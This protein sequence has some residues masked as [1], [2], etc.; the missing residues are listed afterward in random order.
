MLMDR[1]QSPMLLPILVA[2]ATAVWAYWAT[3]AEVVER[4][5]DDPQ[6]SHGFL[7]PLF[8]GYLLWI[9]RGHLRA[10]D[11]NAR[12]W[13]LGIVALAGLLRMLSHFFYQT[14]LDTGS[15]LICLA[16]IAA[17]AGGRRTLIWAGPAILFLIFML[18][19]P[20]RVQTALGGSLQRV[21]TAASTYA[22]Q[23][24]GVPAVSEGNVILLTN[25]RLGVL[26]AC[27][28]LSM[29]FTFFALATA[30]A[31]L[32]PRGWPEKIVIFLSAVPIAIFAN[33][34]RITVTG[35]LF[36]ASRDDLARVVFH[37][38]A[39]WLMMPLALGMLC[40]EL[41]V[42]GRLVVRVGGEVPNPARVAVPA[43][44]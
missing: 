19:L 44:G 34:V 21:A 9:R 25:T 22:L 32:A 30:V 10:A 13:G 43:V 39:G 23:T 3:L 18:P 41:F 24:L 38:L 37:D 15:F 31:I 40:L 42:L 28:G 33:L 35:L 11:L 20:F 12:W 14:W 16:G 7:V 17:A 27:N 29:L 26:E 5:T 1:R 2:L 6:Y 36:E 8:S 4:W